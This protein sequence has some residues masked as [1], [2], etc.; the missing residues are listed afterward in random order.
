MGADTASRTGEADHDIVQAPR[1][2]KSELREQR[3]H[4]G[5]PE[6]DPLNQQRP[7]LFGQAEKV[8]LSERTVFERPVPA[9]RFY[10]A[11]FYLGLQRQARQLIPTDRRSVVC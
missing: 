4:L 1:R 11:R 6:I 2:Q 5:Y 3:L 8:F 9:L 7:V 10:E